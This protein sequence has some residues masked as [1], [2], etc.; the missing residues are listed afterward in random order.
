MMSAGLTMRNRVDNASTICAIIPARGGSK[1]I[2]RKN[3]VRV[4]DRPLIAHSIAHA[5]ASRGI[6]RVIVSTDDPE[7]ATVAKEWGAEVPFLRPEELAGD[8]VLDLPVFRHALLWLRDHEQYEPEIVVHLRPTAPIRLDGQIDRAIE[9]LT[10]HPDA[11]SV[12]SVSLPGAH[13]YRMFTIGDDGFLKPLLDTPHR[14]PYLLRRQDLPPVYWYNCVIDVTRRRTILDLH[15]MTGTAILPFIISPSCVVDIDT[16]DDL[17]IAET[18]MRLLL[19][20]NH[21]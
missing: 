10:S 16:P 4:L 19:G 9:L 15:S 14:E 1:A 5:L 13:P 6:G 20:E 7:I 12:R 18:K 11:D 3:L 2:P 8:T 17:V 21:P